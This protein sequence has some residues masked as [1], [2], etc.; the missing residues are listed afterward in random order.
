MSGSLKRSG[1]SDLQ[2]ATRLV[3]DAVAGL[4]DV[5]EELH[6]NISGLAPIVGPSREGGTRGIPRLVYGSVRGVTRAVGLGL[7]AALSRLTPLLCPTDSSPRR[8]AVLAALNGVIGDYLAETGSALAIPLELRAAGRLLTPETS[9]GDRLL[10]MVHGLCMG[11]LQWSRNGHDHGAALGLELGFKPVYVNY[12]TGLHISTNGHA[13]SAALERLTGEWP[14]P[15]REL[16][17]VAHSMGGLVA[18]S[19][20][21][22][23]SLA[24]ASWPRLLTKVVFLGTPHH[25]AA[26]ERAGNWVV[27]LGSISPYSAPIA[28][29]GRI[30]SSGIRDLRHGNLRDE[31]WQRPDRDHTHDPRAPLPLPA[32]PS[33]FAVAASKASAK[34]RRTGDGLVSVPSAL[35]RHGDPLRSLSIPAERT[36][37]FQGLDHFA[38]LD[39]PGVFE[40][41]RGWLGADGAHGAP[42][43][44]VVG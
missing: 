39:D 30:R 12:N 26:L 38:L 34:G 7:D 24:G 5:V 16:V 6:R 42:E 22:A 32:G 41:L 23:A 37:V 1:A 33:Y 28:R 21:H 40:R 35:G 27:I 4:T 19:A 29:L 20:L 2:G 36:A 25:G 13:L 10:L 3:V 14:V 15:V 18:R 43:G 8:E 44:S 17:V 31:D 9:T 11:D